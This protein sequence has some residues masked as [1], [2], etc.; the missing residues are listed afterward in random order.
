LRLT[1][2]YTIIILLFCTYNGFGQKHA[3]ISGKVTD[4]AGVPLN[5]IRIKIKGEKESTVT[6]LDGKFSLQ[7][8]D[9]KSLEVEFLYLTQLQKM[10]HLDA[11]APGQN[12]DLNTI[13]LKGNFG[14][15]DVIITD[16]TRR[17]NRYMEVI[18]PHNFDNIPNVG[19][20]IE[21]I[22]KTLAGVSS[23]NELSSQYSVRGGNYD[24]N[25]VYINDIE[26]YRPQLVRSG[27]EEGLSIIN[28]D[29]VQSLQFS[30]GGFE[31]RYGDKL[32]SVLDIKYKEPD[33]FALKTNLSFLGASVEAEGSSKDNRFKYIAGIRYRS[34]KYL[35]NSLDVQGDY[36]PTFLD[37]QAY[38]TYDLTDRLR[39][40]YLS[41]YGSNIY[42]SVPQSQTTQFGTVSSAAQF[43]VAFDG[44]QILQYNTFL[45]GLTLDYHPNKR[46]SI[47]FINSFYYT[48]ESENY[49]IVGA[50]K[51]QELNS[52]LGSSGFGSVNY[53]FGLGEFL[54]HAR[55]SFYSEIY[56][57]GVKG[58]H[59]LG[60][61]DLQWGLK[62]QHEHVEASLNE[63]HYLDSVDYS[64]PQTGNP[65]KNLNVYSYLYSRQNND[66]NRYSGYVQG[67]Y[68]IQPKY[69][70]YLTVGVRTNYWDF[71]KE[72]L[73]SP[74]AQITY[75]PNADFNRRIILGGY[76]DS[77][78]KK[79]IRLRG[80]VGIYQQ[81]AFFK[82][83][84]DAYGNL[85]PGI[86]AQKS[87]HFV[88]G[89]DVTF[90]MW[91]RP[92]KWT[93]ELYY[94]YMWDLIPYQIDN[95][96]ITYLGKND[97]VGYATGVD[98]QLNGELVKD[99]PSWVSLSLLDTR[100]NLTD[101]SY[102]T[103]DKKTGK[104]ITVYPGYIPRPTD[105]RVRFSLFFQD[106]IPKHPT[107]KVHLNLVFGSGL[108]FGPPNLNRYQDTLRLPPY[109]RVDIGFS[110]QFWDK[111][112]Q[113][114]NSRVLN[115]FRS[116]WFSVE[117]F[118][119]LQI[120]NTVAYLWIQDISGNQWAVPSY[121]TTRR[122][123]LHLEL[124]F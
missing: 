6:G 90:K 48:D 21:G 27:Q 89:S 91:D 108:P 105:Q 17:K 87:S 104:P 3:F 64:V 57:S 101:D 16:S 96:H 106:Y 42:L 97:A 74:R 41:Y 83:L 35:L 46:N 51:L 82:E 61:I 1:A 70:S 122:L 30:A 26:V 100:E 49:D 23:N 28:T 20:G 47:K 94:K 14:I 107:Y 84:F 29:M 92:F 12:Y 117:V 33:S 63:Y 60:A 45:N 24:E 77:L 19:G 86:K 75:E 73:V 79:N 7:V 112:K 37:G 38:L 34:S 99:A 5:D 40:G 66:W 4:T 56:N 76:D 71:N 2:Y 93:T 118:N 9:G 53:T 39:V 13:A 32:S 11:L 44:Q 119:L 50:Y 22:L 102:V 110:K 36:Q 120:N 109:R 18:N 124:K 55:N 78:Q 80:A 54:Y 123:N 98:F 43:V 31:A 113:R 72:L 10:I 88:L 81:P 116:I 68:N 115:A 95:V 103:Q 121:L 62:Y 52:D 25:L 65:R 15:N 58:Y 59:T 85:V 8:P 69:N 67:T 111:S 114:S